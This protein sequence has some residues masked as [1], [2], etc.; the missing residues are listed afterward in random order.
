MDDFP[1]G[2]NVEKHRSTRTYSN[3]YPKI[4][5]KRNTPARLNQWAADS[6]R[7]SLVLR[8]LPFSYEQRKQNLSQLFLRA[9][10][11]A[12]KFLLAY[13]RSLRLIY[14]EKL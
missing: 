8:P 11:R 3:M 1:V 5:F 13:N 12:G 4:L 14:I 10:L 7:R 9:R 6:R 2:K